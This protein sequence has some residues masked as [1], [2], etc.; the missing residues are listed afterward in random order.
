[1]RASKTANPLI[2][3]PGALALVALLAAGCPADAPPVAPQSA[4]RPSRS[5]D[6]SPL[7]LH[8]PQLDQ[9]IVRLDPTKPE[10]RRRYY[11]DRWHPDLRAVRD[12]VVDK[13]RIYLLV[14]SS[15][16]RA[17]RQL[18]V[19]DLASGKLLRTLALPAEPSALSWVGAG[20][21]AVCHTTPTSGAPGRVT[22][23]ATKALTIG[24]SIPLRGACH[25]L[26]TDAGGSGR[27]A[28]IERMTRRYGADTLVHHRLVMVD[29]REGKRLAQRELPA[30]A[31]DVAL[32]PRGLLYVSFASGGGLHATDA[33]VGVYHPKDLRLVSRLKLEMVARVMTAHRGRLVLGLLHR[34]EAWLAAIDP[35]SR[36]TRFD[37]RFSRL[38][39]DQLA[40]V[41]DVAYL[42]LRGEH[43]LERV[44]L[45]GDKRMPRLQLGK[46]PQG[47]DRV[48]LLRTARAFDSTPAGAAAASSGKK[49]AR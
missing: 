44:D 8:Y 21:L 37:L 42:P 9:R 40:I 4:L 36:Q 20:E 45:R 49:G 11:P 30:G 39:A 3:W 31:R 2:F 34:G 7:F 5:A 18:F 46:L 28:V 27:A 1:V 12:F 38:V 13:A 6:R 25:A 24:R 10:V 17:H 33:T 19:A 16:A 48:T 15:D 35:A 47:R 23:I 43:A 26:A 22:T 41:G 29:L 32:G 14:A